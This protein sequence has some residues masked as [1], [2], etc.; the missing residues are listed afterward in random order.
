MA[1]R[2]AAPD[3]RRVAEAAE[4]IRAAERPL[5]I[6]G[7]GVLYSE[8]EEAL[9]ELAAATGIPVAE[10]FAG[11][12]AVQVDEWLQLGG[13]GLEGNPAASRLAM[14]A[15]LVLAVGTRL[16]DFATGS[17]SPS[18]S[19]RTCASSPSTSGDA[20]RTSRAR[21]PSSATR[22]RRS[23]TAR[24]G[25]RRLV[26][27]RGVPRRGRARSEWLDQARRCGTPSRARR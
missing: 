27:V 3:P 16:T 24:E 17:N 15:D 12:G 7:G 10:T 21:C 25:A 11:K 2:A 9:A 1:D 5:V 13:V 18:S 14:D 8:A 20:T 22:A 4:L 19:T 6:A 23:R 26:D